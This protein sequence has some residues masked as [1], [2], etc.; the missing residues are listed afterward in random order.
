MDRR[1][2]LAK[3]ALAAA[4]IGV[5]VTVTSCGE[6]NPAGPAGNGNVTGFATGG[7]HSHTGVITRAQ[8]DAGMAVTVT[9]TG[10]GHEH[11]LPLDDAQVQTIAMGQRV[12]VSNFVNPSDPAV[13]QHAHDYT[14]N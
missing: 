3:A 1:E 13:S 10:G 9:F 5:K 7:G 14:F 12:V 11:H 2:F 6:D 4:L 8:L